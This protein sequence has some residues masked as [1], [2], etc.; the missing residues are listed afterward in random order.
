MKERT[1]VVVACGR[2]WN[3]NEVVWVNQEYTLDQHLNENFSVFDREQLV[4]SGE[5]TD[6]SMNMLSREAIRGAHYIVVKE[7]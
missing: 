2:G 3:R 4:N 7:L 1:F 5:I 6:D